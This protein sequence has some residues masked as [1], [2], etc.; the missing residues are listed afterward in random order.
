M[1]VLVLV[2][3][4][5]E[6]VLC[7]NKNDFKDEWM[8]EYAGQDGAETLIPWELRS[9]ENYQPRMPLNDVDENDVQVDCPHEDVENLV[10]WNDPTL[11]WPNNNDN[12][13]GPPLADGSMITLPSETAVIIRSGML[14]GTSTSPYGQIVVPSGSRLI[15]DDTDENDNNSI[16]ELHTLGIKVEGTLEAGSPTCRIDGRIQITLHGTYDPPPP[17]SPNSDRY[18]ASPN[19]P[20]VD[21]K[22]IV[23]TDTDGARWDFHGKLYQPTWTRLAAHIPG[24]DTGEGTPSIRNSVLFLQDCVNWPLGGTIVVTTSQLKDTRSYNYNEQGIISFESNA[25]ECVSIDGR[26]YGKITLTQPLVHYHHAGEN[27]YQCEVMLLTRNIV[28]E[29]NQYSEPTDTTPLGCDSL[30]NGFTDEP[31]LNYLTGFGGHSIIIGQSVG[32]IRGVEFR[33]MGMTNVVGRYPVHFHYSTTGSES[34]VTDSS[35]HRSYYRAYV[36]HNTFNLRVLSNVCYDVSGHAY[37]LE[38]GVEEFNRVEYNLAAFVH[39]INGAVIMGA[40][41]DERPQTSSIAVPADHTASGFYISNVHNY[42][43]GNAASGGWAG[44]QFPI[45]PQPADPNLRFNGVVPKDR[46][47]LVVSGNSVHSSSWFGL[48]TGA[49]YSGGSLYWE[50]DDLESEVLKY[51]AGREGSTRLTRHTKDEEGNNA[52]FEVWNSTAWLVNVG[53]TGWGK[54]SEIRGFEAHDFTR[55][56]IFVLFTVWLDSIVLNC[57]TSNA[58][59]VLEPGSGYNENKF[60]DGKSWSGFFTYDH[61]M[62]HILTDWK[63]SNCGGVARGLDPWVPGGP[64]DTGNNAFF[65]VPVNGFAPEIQLISSGFQYD[66]DTV[67]GKGF[68]DESI[69]FAGSGAQDIYSMQY[70]SNWEDADGS[71]TQS[72][73]RTVIGPARAGKWWRLDYRLGQCEVRSQWKFPQIL[74][75]KEDRHLASMFT[76]VM[77]QKGT[78]RS[79][80][81]DMI[82]TNGENDRK[83]RQG[84]MTHFGFTGDSSV[85]SCT[86]PEICDETTSRS[87]DADITGPYN[88]AKYGGWHLSFDLG[89]PA[90]LTV[91][92]IQMEEGTIMLQAMNLPPNTVSEDIRIW[93]ESKNRAYDFSLASSLDDVRTAEKGDLYWFDLQTK[94]LYWRVISGYVDKDLTFDW[95]DRNEFGR[96]AFTRANLSVQDIMSKNEFQLHIDINCTRD[97]NAADA[98][99]LEKPAFI[100]PGMGCPEG[101]VMLSID[102]CGL[103]CELENNCTT[104]PPTSSPTKSPTGSPTTSATDVPTSNPTKSPTADPTDIPT[105]SPTSIPTASPTPKCTNGADYNCA[106]LKKKNCDKL[107]KKTGFIPRLMCP[108][109]CKS[110]DDGDRC[111]DAKKAFTIGDSNKPIYKRIFFLKVGKKKKKFTSCNKITSN[112]CDKQSFK[113]KGSKKPNYFIV[114]Q[115]CRKKCGFCES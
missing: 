32:R 17:T 20:E 72:D 52:W 49:F 102:K 15:F 18:L 56:G 113:K 111:E 82:Y 69:F 21:T 3:L 29:G 101:K 76:V 42:I 22:G 83:T 13:A 75:K 94:T 70:M 36:V 67:G 60:N 26:E 66:W 95:I 114:H 71:M 10:E 93:A 43:I 34:M 108:E 38:S 110:C 31:C 77:P 16:I 59:Q 97:E 28:I 103:P 73:G 99:C 46:M 24:N 53:A 89:T 85:L 47:A 14:V 40:T 81:F 68:T 19:K 112:Q 62:Q 91:Q 25:V 35:V 74:C 115:M 105:S 50:E 79:A 98:F 106:K 54:R 12:D 2:L 87:W 8:S 5:F 39:V 51:N 84:S 1:I 90:E 11:E 30:S 107:D 41:D 4:C 88:H 23:I 58:P 64:E 6:V 86:P 9:I 48:N 92:R 33:K 37:Y 63:I 45:L 7:S 100:V 80:V 109:K 96:E 78:Q 61:L 27:E 65:T 57:R 44:I 55:R 104:P